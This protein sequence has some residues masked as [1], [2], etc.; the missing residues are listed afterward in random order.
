[1]HQHIKL[2]KVS[3]ILQIVLKRRVTIQSR[4]V[5]N[6]IM[7]DVVHSGA[8]IRQLTRYYM[9]HG[10]RITHPAGKKKSAGGPYADR[11]C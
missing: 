11:W 8:R 4:P 3:L 6:I 9:L 2:N 10:R 7:L 1:M 5:P